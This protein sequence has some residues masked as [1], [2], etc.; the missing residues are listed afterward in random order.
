MPFILGDEICDCYI[1]LRQDKDSRRKEL[2]ESFRFLCECPACVY[3]SSF[4]GS[5]LPSSSSSSSSSFPSSSS[6]SSSSSSSSSSFP[7]SSCLDRQLQFDGIVVGTDGNI[8]DLK[9]K[10]KTEKENERERER[11]RK[12]DDEDRLFAAC[13]EDESIDF[14]VAGQHSEAL[15]VLH[16]GLSVLQKP[17]N[18][19]WSIRYQAGAHL[20][21]HQ[22]LLHQLQDSSCH[23]R[24]GNR[25]TSINSNRGGR[26]TLEKRS[27]RDKLEAENAAAEEEEITIAFMRKHLHQAHLLNLQLQG[28]T[29]P[30]TINTDLLVKK[31][32]FTDNFYSNY[33]TD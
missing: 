27:R 21:V 23:D 15:K 30:E 10:N 18:V 16:R 26:S 22:V 32:C 5:T 4:D 13:F 11:K 7:S 12:E 9:N 24:K 1:D 17:C 33:L 3:P 8:E 6:A 25:S 29:C 14:I 2:L 20:M 19:P 31:H 28:P